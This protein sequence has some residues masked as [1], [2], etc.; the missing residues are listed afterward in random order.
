MIDDLKSSIQGAIHKLIEDGTLPEGSPDSVGLERTRDSNH[1]DF[2]T[3]VAMT[4]ARPARRNPRELAGLL[5]DKLERPAR[6]EKIEIAGPGFINF[7]VHGSHWQEVVQRILDQGQG[8]GLAEKNSGDSILLEFVS[9]NPTGP[10]HVGHGRGAAYG[11]SLGNLLEA[12]GHR[13]H[14]EYYVND[15]GR[16]MDILAASTIIRA[17]EQQGADIPFPVNGYRGDYVLDI[18]HTLIKQ[19]PDS[20]L[21][22]SAYDFG[23]LPEDGE[24]TKE[25]FIDALIELLRTTLGTE[26]FFEIQQF[27]LTTILE[28]I[29]ED[30]GEFGVNYDEWF[31]ERGLGTSG[32][33]QEEL[34]QLDQAGHLFEQDGALWFRSTDFGDDKDRVLRRDN[35]QS[36]YFASDVAYH[37]DKFARGFDRCVNIWGADHHGYI[38]RVRAAMQALHE[39]PPLLQIHLVQFANLYRGEEKVPM[40]TRSGSFVT[41]RDLRAEVGS[42]A[43]RF[44]Y[45]MRKSDQHMDFDL[46]LAKSQSRDNPVYYIQYAHARVCRLMEK[47]TEQGLNW[48][49]GDGLSSLDLLG[50][51]LEQELLTKLEEYPQMVARAAEQA[52]PHSVANYLRELS[53]RFHVWYNAHRALVDD[54]ALRNARIALCLAVR[55]VVANGLTLLGVSAPERM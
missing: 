47:L 49:M 55:Q 8:Y 11:A 17:L 38:P 3:N 5:I 7:F 39:K 9:A 27:A 29:R 14:R 24:D 51:D 26:R 48:D 35:G 34:D 33:I 50:E 1:G 40:S 19:H 13:V 46:E 22:A 25:Q 41:L 54:P 45:V 18:A 6:V 44:F 36:T 43:A 2:A 15:M 10:L 4:L 21:P 31:S 12:A 52:A 20:L 42:D 23:S 16:Q 30:L 28:D 53:G 37:M 32:R